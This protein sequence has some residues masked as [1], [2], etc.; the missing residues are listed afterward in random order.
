MGATAW[1]DPDPRKGVVYFSFL[2]RSEDLLTEV[3]YHVEVTVVDGRV[4]GVKV[5][6][7]NVFL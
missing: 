1:P 2:T 7:L 3:R 4:T 5:V 6:A